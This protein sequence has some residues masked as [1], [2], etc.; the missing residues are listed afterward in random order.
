[1]M[2]DGPVRRE[3]DLRGMVCPGPTGDTLQALKQLSPG[4]RLTVI[5]DYLPARQTLPRLLEERGHRW[6]ITKDDGTTFHMNI[7]KG[8]IHG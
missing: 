2:P 5:L 4:D 3:L 1:M 6:Q 7:E 8:A